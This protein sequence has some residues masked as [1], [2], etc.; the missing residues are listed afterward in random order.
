MKWNAIDDRWHRLIAGL[1]AKYEAF[2]RGL[3]WDWLAKLR[4]KDHYGE[5]LR[6]GQPTRGRRHD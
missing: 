5:P 1:D 2:C 3:A 6:T 4:L